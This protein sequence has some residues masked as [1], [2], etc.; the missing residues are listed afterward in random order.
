MSV[1]HLIEAA[2]RDKGSEAKLASACSVS[3]AAIWKAKK[4]GR[5]SPRLAIK[6]ECACG[7]SRRL[8]CPE[9]FGSSAQPE[10]TGAAA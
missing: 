1:R 9:I 3:Q 4:A 6:I 8:L 2:I 10:T 5:C 7:I